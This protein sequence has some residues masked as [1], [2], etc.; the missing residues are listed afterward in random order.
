MKW[1]NLED[2]LYR[3]SQSQRDKYYYDSICIEYLE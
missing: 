1:M 2:M 3:I